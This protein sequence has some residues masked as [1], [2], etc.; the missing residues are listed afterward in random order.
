MNDVEFA[1]DVNH[2]PVNIER[3]RERERK[4]VDLSEINVIEMPVPPTFGIV[5]SGHNIN[6][7]GL[8]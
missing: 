3:E 4:N 1:N 6:G 5:S 2:F 7:V 8:L